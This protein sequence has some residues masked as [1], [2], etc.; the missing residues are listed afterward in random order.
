MQD[1][2][3]ARSLAEAALK[4][5]ARAAPG[6]VKAFLRKGTALI[7]DFCSLNKPRMTI[8][9]AWQIVAVHFSSPCPRVPFLC[10]HFLTA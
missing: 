4:R 2:E 7:G 1:A 10:S 6:Y 3:K 9:L 8:Y 5:D